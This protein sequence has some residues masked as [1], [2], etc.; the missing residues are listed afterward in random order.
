MCVLTIVFISKLAVYRQ[1]GLLW[2]LFDRESYT[3]GCVWRF[4]A[5]GTPGKGN[6][7]SMI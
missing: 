4:K 5:R 6:F 3:E 7:S 1:Y 2:V